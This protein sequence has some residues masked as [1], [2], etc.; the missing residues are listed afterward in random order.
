[1][2]VSQI[3]KIQIISLAAFSISDM[4]VCFAIKIYN[5]CSIH[6]GASL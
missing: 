3:S 2:V 1:M 6:Y 4:D 5:K